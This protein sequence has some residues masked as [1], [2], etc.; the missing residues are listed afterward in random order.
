MVLVVVL[1]SFKFYIL[2]LLALVQCHK[3]KFPKINTYPLK[4][5]GKTLQTSGSGTRWNRCISPYV[6]H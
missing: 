5:K 6:F 2:N 1:L 3:I 4:R